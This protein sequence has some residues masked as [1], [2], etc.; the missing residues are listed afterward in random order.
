MKPCI[1][2]RLYIYIYIYIYIFL[3]SRSWCIGALDNGIL[4]EFENGDEGKLTWHLHERENSIRQS[5]WLVTN[6]TNIP[7]NSNT[8]CHEVCSDRLNQC[9][10]TAHKPVFAVTN[11]TNVF[12]WHI[13]TNSKTSSLCLCYFS[14]SPLL[15]KWN[16]CVQIWRYDQN[17]SLLFWHEYSQQSLIEV[18]PRVF[19]DHAVNDT[20]SILPNL[21]QN[22]IF[23]ESVQICYLSGSS[24]SWKWQN[25]HLHKIYIQCKPSVAGRPN[26]RSC[27]MSQTTWRSQSS[28]CI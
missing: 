8:D 16:V 14:S 5:R 6:V 12:L 27:N 15:Q 26:I 17:F 22:S 7:W 11:V 4:D 18:I 24:T 23:R 1:C 2:C 20:N 28:T 13:I 9:E 3:F 25:Y 21:I 10:I 19:W